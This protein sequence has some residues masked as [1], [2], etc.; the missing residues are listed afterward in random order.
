MPYRKEKFIE[1]H[2]YHVI[3]KRFDGLSLFRTDRDRLRFLLSAHLINWISPGIELKLSRLD[4]F[5]MSGI[6]NGAVDIK[7]VYKDLKINSIPLVGINHFILMKNHVHFLL[8]QISEG[9]VQSFIQRLQNSYSK[10]HNKKYSRRGP[11]FISPFKTI[12]VTDDRHLRYLT[13][14]ISL[15]ALDTA[16]IEWRNLNLKHS[17]SRVK[18][19]LDSYPW[20]GY[21]YLMGK[22]NFRVLLENNLV[23]ELF[24]SAKQF[25]E[26]LRSWRGDESLDIN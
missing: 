24:P 26:H 8:R 18:T 21:H 22:N 17:W 6:L 1:N 2:F 12:P 14:Y 9:G 16:R 25:E 10:F 11:L 15:N 4:T 5:I 23:K 3:P 19:I 7:S 20:S 13:G